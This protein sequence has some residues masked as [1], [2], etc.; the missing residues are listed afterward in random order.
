[1]ARHHNTISILALCLSI[2]FFWAPVFF[3]LFLQCSNSIETAW[4]HNVFVC[5]LFDARVQVVQHKNW[6]E[7]DGMRE[8]NENENRRKINEM[9][10]K[11]IFFICKQNAFQLI[12]NISIW[13]VFVLLWMFECVWVCVCVSQ[14]IW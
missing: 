7:W 9:K 6:S 11:M 14:W 1:M 12:F 5:Y 8:S 2:V 13:F 4:L 10:R 3:C